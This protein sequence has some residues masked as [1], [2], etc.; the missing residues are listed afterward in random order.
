VDISDGAYH[1]NFNV[2][3]RAFSGITGG[4]VAERASRS[5]MEAVPWLGD[6]KLNV[7]I[8]APSFGVRTRLV[9]GQTD[10]DLNMNLRLLGTL[11]YPEL[12]DRIEVVSGGTFT[13]DVVRR[14]F[15][16]TRGTVDFDGDYTHPQID[17]QARTRIEYKNASDSVVSA[18]RFN[19]DDSQDSFYSDM[20]QVNLAV[21][22]TYPDLD[23]QITSP[24]RGLSS[25]DLQVLLL[26]G[27]AP[28]ESISDSGG[29]FVNVNLLTGGVTDSLVKVLLADLVDSV[30][31]GVTA[32]GDV[33][34]DVSAH[35]GRRLKFQTQVQQ[36][37]GSSQYSTGFK[38]RLTDGLSLEG[39]LRAV[40]YS[41]DEED[42]GRNYDTKLRYRIPIE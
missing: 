29:S 10:L 41:V 33:N 27:M 31:F 2:V 8:R 25:N 22:G 37:S 30:S 36:G 13:Y 4:R 19:A 20:I 6:T 11:R 35:M 16:V 9:V 17:L 5:M 42:V 1:K 24:T 12:W 7:A 26:T 14:E 3:R 28:G 21:S 34:L 32:G 23:I 40:E 18:S 39:R 15:E 38:I